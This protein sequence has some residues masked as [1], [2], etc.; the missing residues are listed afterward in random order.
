MKIL[1]APGPY[2]ECLSAEE[3][4]S[5]ISDGINSVDST[6]QLINFPLC[7]GGTGFVKRLIERKNGIIR[8]SRVMG[9]LG[10][11]IEVFYGEIENKTAIIESYAVCG[12]ALVPSVQ[13]NPLLTTT[14]GIGQLIDELSSKEY[15]IIILGIGDSSTNDGGAGVIQAL[16]VRILDENGRDIG[17][18]GGQLLRAKQID[19][20]GYKKPNLEE[21]VVACNLSSVLC[22]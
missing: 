7:D 5:S 14:Y 21:I 20:S 16:G 8:K 10:Y 17:L 3:V 9:P 18:G 22:G 6:H 4:A 1:I 13:R 19:L 11:D 12:L 2:K 15:K